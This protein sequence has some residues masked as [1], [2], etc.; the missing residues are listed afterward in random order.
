MKKTLILISAVTAMIAFPA[1]AQN[2]AASAAR[3][4]VAAVR[5]AA[6]TVVQTKGSKDAVD[7]LKAAVSTVKADVQAVRADTDASKQEI[8]AA[9]YQAV[10]TKATLAFLKALAAAP[11][12]RLATELHITDIDSAVYFYSAG[13]HRLR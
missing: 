6:V 2:A 10:Q 5:A 13:V 4:N 11:K 3:A 9:T 7:A 1:Q 12:S 8:A